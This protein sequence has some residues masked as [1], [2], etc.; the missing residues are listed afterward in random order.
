MASA[1]AHHAQLVAPLCSLQSPCKPR[2]FAL[3]Y[4][5]LITSNTVSTVRVHRSGWCAPTASCLLT[6][7][8]WWSRGR[9]DLQQQ[10]V[11]A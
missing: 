6:A 2:S 10:Q 4:L 11:G 1:G 8:W 9:G 5:H 3:N 7:L